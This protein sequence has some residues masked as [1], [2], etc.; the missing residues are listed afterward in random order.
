MKLRL[1]VLVAALALAGCTTTCDP[2]QGGFISGVNGLVSNCYTNNANSQQAQLA[3]LQAQ[4]RQAELQAQQ[5]HQQVLTQQAQLDDLRANVAHLDEKLTVMRGKIAQLKTQN[6]AEAENV[7]DL[8]QT[9]GLQHQQLQRL[10]ARLQGGDAGDPQVEQQY[11]SLKRAIQAESA[12]LQ[13]DE[14]Q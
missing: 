12:Q 6:S 7:A 10:Q 1:P 9:I 14:G 4:Q 13:R 5:A 8:S 3:Q 2:S 11:E